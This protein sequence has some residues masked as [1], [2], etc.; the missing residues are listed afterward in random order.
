MQCDNPFKV[1]ETTRPIGFVSATIEYMD[2]RPSEVIEAV[3]NTVLRTGR[4]ALA[5]CLAGETG[6]EFNFFVS[7]MLFGDGGTAGGVPKYVNTERN[8]LFGTTRA[9]KP[10][11]ATIDPTFPSQVTFTSVVAYSEANGYSLN[12]MAL[13]M[14]NGD[15]YSMSTFPDMGKTALMQITWNW[16]LA[17]V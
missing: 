1:A 16:R 6:D 8:G 13:Q 5:K 4:E 3:Q 11:I 17:F 10:V 9:S 14:N 2:G 12:E 7:R 15:L